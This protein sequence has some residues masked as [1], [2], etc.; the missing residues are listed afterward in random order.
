MER[1]DASEFTL[2]GFLRKCQSK[3]KE[4]FFIT[5]M[6]LSANHITVCSWL[7]AAAAAAA[8]AAALC[9]YFDLQMALG[10]LLLHL[11]IPEGGVCGEYVYH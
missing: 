9:V 1:N 5:D 3:K 2:K 4:G 6:L 11:I 8:A 10:C 7:M